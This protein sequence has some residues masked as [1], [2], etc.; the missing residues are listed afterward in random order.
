MILRGQVNCSLWNH[1]DLSSNPDP[2]IYD[3]CDL[4]EGHTFSPSVQQDCEDNESTH[5]IQ[6]GQRMG[7]EFKCLQV[8]FYLPNPSNGPYLL[9]TCWRPGP[10]LTASQDLIKLPYNY[11]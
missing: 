6:H 8:P 9:S 3:Q 10:V 11:L 1:P 5:L 7:I 2:T 4:E